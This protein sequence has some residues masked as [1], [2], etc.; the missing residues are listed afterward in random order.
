MG[1][2]MKSILRVDNLKGKDRKMDG[3]R[4]TQKQTYRLTNG[5]KDR[6]RNEIKETGKRKEGEQR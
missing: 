5:Q 6:H 3:R 4:C 2:P 1:K